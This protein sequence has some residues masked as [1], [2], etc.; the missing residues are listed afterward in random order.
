M[1]TT[2]FFREDY[3]PADHAHGIA[4][5]TR[6]VIPVRYSRYIHVLLWSWFCAWGMAEIAVIVMA[7]GV[8]PGSTPPPP[9][10]PGAA[11]VLLSL[12]TIAGGFMAWR[13][14]WASCGREILDVQET[15][16]RLRRVPGFFSTH[17]FDRTKVRNVHIGSYRREA[18]Y[19]SWGRN[20]VGKG[21][22]FIA[23]DYEGRKV[24]IARG[25]ERK[26]AAYLLDLIRPGGERSLLDAEQQ[27]SDPQSQDPR[28]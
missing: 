8:F 18:I 23:F 20:F 11:V 6:V 10:P 14:L 21:D 12:F 27:E 25:L 7:L 5:S 26:D 4:G 1:E 19:P 16:L 2:L 9:Q 13:L 15:K 24:E 17:E 22:C 3:R 28:R